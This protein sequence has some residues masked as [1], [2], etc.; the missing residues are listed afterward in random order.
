[1]SIAYQI[2]HVGFVAVP[3]IAGR[4]ALSRWGG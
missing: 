4:W 1:L 3:V 2:L